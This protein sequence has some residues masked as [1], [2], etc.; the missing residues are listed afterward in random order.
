MTDRIEVL[1]GS[2]PSGDSNSNYGTESYA[3]SRNAFQN[4]DEEGHAWDITA[5]LLENLLPV[6][7]AVHTRG[8]A[9]LEM[10]IVH[11]AL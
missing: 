1:S 9:Q 10:E 11:P 3:P 4:A 6:P 8:S 5:N 2:V 7:N